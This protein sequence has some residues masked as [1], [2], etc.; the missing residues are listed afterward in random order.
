M[1]EMSKEDKRREHHEHHLYHLSALER[2]LDWRQHHRRGGLRILVF[3]ILQRGPRNGAEI[4]NQIESASHGHWRP[5]PGSIYPLLEQLCKEESISKR[6]DGK[7]E[8]TEKGK[9]DF[10]WPY[11]LYSKEPRSPDDAIEEMNSY[12]SYLED[13]KRMDHSK[14]NP[15]VDELKKVRDRLTT[16]IDIT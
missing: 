10:K 8:I 5:S 11:E 6:E 2:H 15:H 1:V 12:I 4:M 13:L 3:S 7:Y 9:K 16:L 14:I